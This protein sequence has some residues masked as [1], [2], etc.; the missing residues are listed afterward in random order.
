[1]SRFAF[2]L[3]LLAGCAAP[4]VALDASADPDPAPAAE[5]SLA[6][7][8][9]APQ[10]DLPAPLR[11]DAEATMDHAAHAGL[12]APMGEHEMGEHEMGQHAMDEH[13]MDDRQMP[14]RSHL[15]RALDAYHAIGDALET[16]DLAPVATQARTLADAWALAAETA[17]EADPHFWHARMPQTRAVRTRALA[18]TRAA[19]LESA[20]Q[21]FRQ[22]RAPFLALTDAFREAEHGAE[23]AP[24]P[25]PGDHDGMDHDGMDHGAEPAP[26]PDPRGHDETNHAG[27][28]R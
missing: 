28:D 13:A 3:G 27:H 24:D 8:P 14:E 21:T 10:P 9:P 5:V 6:A 11:P 2:A 19:S 4:P 12:A 17:P 22:L 7:L 23:P 25:D 1:M 26:D 18:L 16:G 15:S 20:R